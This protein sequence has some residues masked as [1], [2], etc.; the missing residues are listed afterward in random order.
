ME[1]A[2]MQQSVA[3]SNFF[4][5]GGKSKALNLKSQGR[6]PINCTAQTA[7]SSPAALKEPASL[8]AATYNPPATAAARKQ[9]LAALTPML[10]GPPTVARHGG[11][12]NSRTPDYATL[13]LLSALNRAYGDLRNITQPSLKG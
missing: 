11:R 4:C 1:A 2:C 10:H 5:G 6:R 9:M 12:L 7:L 13:C 8:D 3:N